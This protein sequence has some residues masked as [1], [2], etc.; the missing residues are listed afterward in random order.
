LGAA[1][2][3]A[4]SHAVYMEPLLRGAS[5]Q[6]GGLAPAICP[7][8]LLVRPIFPETAA[9]TA[10]MAVQA[11]RTGGGNARAFNA[12]ARIITFERRAGTALAP[13]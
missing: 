13:W 5:W 1:C 3:L 8:A 7:G 10:G 4:S 6:R 9:R 11:R 2:S 12:G